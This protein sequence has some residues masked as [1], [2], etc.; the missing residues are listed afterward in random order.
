MFSQANITGDATGG[1]GPGSGGGGAGGGNASATRHASTRSFSSTSAASSSSS[2]PLS[3]GMS[4]FDA[5]STGSSAGRGVTN[6]LRKLSIGQGQNLKSPSSANT[7]TPPTFSGEA[8][9][10][11]Q[12]G[13]GIAAPAPTPVGSMQ[14]SSSSSGVVVPP[15]SAPA[16]YGG[17][18]NLNNPPSSAN[19]GAMNDSLLAHQQQ[20]RTNG[21]NGGAISAN[22]LAAVGSA[23]SMGPP[24][25]GR[26]GRQPSMS[27]EGT[28]R[29]PS[30]MGERLL[31]GHFAH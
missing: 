18:R 3:T 8:A 25:K 26:R 22:D 30:P 21:A 10:Q 4:N 7:V 13:S 12:H 15:S 14:P 23:P 6:L 29:R 20:T 11:G 17:F 9:T 27:G 5:S 16:Q 19:A 31:M 24:P 1:N 28:K 2:P